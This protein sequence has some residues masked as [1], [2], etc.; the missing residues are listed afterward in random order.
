[1]NKNPTAKEIANNIEK[2][3]LMNEEEFEY[4]RKSSFEIWKKDFDAEI[5]YTHQLKLMNVIQ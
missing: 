4:F 3:A 2:F 5:N 1:M